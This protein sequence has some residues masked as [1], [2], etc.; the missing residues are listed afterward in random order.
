MRFYN[1]ETDD[2]IIYVAEQDSSKAYKFDMDV[3]ARAGDFKYKSGLY[4][5]YLIVGDSSISNSFQWLVADIE[6]KFP[7]NANQGGMLI[8]CVIHE[9]K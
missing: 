2:E 9:I 6:I 5:I 1:K 7:A 4:E 3:G 8:F